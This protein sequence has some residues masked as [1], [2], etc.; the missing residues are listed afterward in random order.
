MAGLGVVAAADGVYPLAGLLGIGAVIAGRRLLDRRRNARKELWRR[1]RA[2]AVEL[3]RVARADGIAAP[4]MKRGVGLQEGVLESWV[5]LPEESG[6]FLP[7]DLYTLGEGPPG[8]GHIARR[9][10]G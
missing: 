10:A 7:A 1:A 5:L 6:P 8:A 2:N 4:Q 3:G 9:R